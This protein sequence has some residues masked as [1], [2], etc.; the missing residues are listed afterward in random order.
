MITSER[1]VVPQSLEVMVRELAEYELNFLDATTAGE[2]LAA[3]LR[4]KYADMSYSELVDA[5]A[6]MSK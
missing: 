3:L 5:Y 6:D 4:Q 1:R 2:M